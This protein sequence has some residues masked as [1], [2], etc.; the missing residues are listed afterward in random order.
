MATGPS[1][2]GVASARRSA[3][4]TSTR[5]VHRQQGE[6]RS[7]FGRSGA[8]G[9]RYNSLLLCTKRRR[10]VLAPHASK[11]PVPRLSRISPC[12]VSGSKREATPRLSRLAPYK[13]AVAGNRLDPA[14]RVGRAPGSC[15]GSLA[16]VRGFEE[17]RLARRVRGDEGKL[18]APGREARAH[19]PLVGVSASLL[20]RH[21]LPAARHPS[22]DRARARPPLERRGDGAEPRAD[23]H[24]GSAA[25]VTRRHAVGAHYGLMDWLVQRLTAVVMAVYTLLVL[26]IAL[27]NGGIDYPLW[28]DLFAHGGFKLASFLFM[29]AL[30]YHA[31]IGVRDILMDYIKP[32]GIRLTLETV[33]VIALVG[34]LGWT[35]Q[36]LWGA[37]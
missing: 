35:L 4:I 1:N 33:T 8:C 25:V 7:V 26:A 32:A 29:V 13:A 10:A 11:G 3:I 20:R 17:P 37:T 31:W 22:R 14:P 30:L 16:A 24:R 21:S 6:S 27:W 5:S 23:A 36:V 18:F 34:Y 9:S 19:R 15:R 28:T 2:G 12:A